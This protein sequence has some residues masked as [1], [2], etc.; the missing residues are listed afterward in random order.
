M[1][2]FY[3]WGE[4]GGAC[5]E[6]RL[7]NRLSRGFRGCPQSL[8]ANIWMVSEIGPWRL[9]STPSPVYYSLSYHLSGRL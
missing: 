6:C 2:G 9:V 7:E 8:Q 3:P 4:G 5:F 1:S